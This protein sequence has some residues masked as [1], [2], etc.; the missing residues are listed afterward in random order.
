MSSR[1]AGN[2]AIT[3]RHPPDSRLERTG[4][5][6]IVC[7]PG[8]ARVVLDEALAHLWQAA[9]GQ[10][11]ARLAET[12]GA[13]DP[14]L[15]AKLLSLRAA[16]LLLPPLDVA[17]AGT[18]SP[19]P[20]PPPLVSAVIVS[21]NGCHHLEACLPSL[22]AQTYTRLEIILVDD[23]ST[24]GTETYVRENFPAVRLVRQ[25]NG[26]NFAAGC[27]HGIAHARGDL[28]F[29]LNNDT[30]LDPHC[31][32]ELVAAQ[33]GQDDVGGVAAMMRFY[34][35]RPFVNGL[36]AALRRFGFGYDLGIGSLDVG[37]F[38]IA[39]EV[40]LLCFG[41]ALI[42]RAAF[43]RTGPI[44][45]VYH[46]YYEDT[47][48]SYR[49]RAL[50]FRLVA[51]P[52]ALVYHKFGAST[53][54]LPSAF[55]KRLATRN[56]LWFVIK[57]F[58]AATI[59]LQ[60]LLYFTDDWGHLLAHLA[61][62]EWRL[63]AAIGRA[64]LGFWRGL[65]G[66]LAGRRR[67]WI[68][69]KRAAV[70]LSKLAAPFPPPQMHG[71]LPRL[72]AEL[73]EK[74]YQPFL[75]PLTHSQTRPLAHSP[76]RPRLLIISP[77][78]INASMGGV[79]IRY[80]ELARQLTS[81]ADVTLAVPNQSDLA[82]SEVAIRCYQE[83]HS[84]TLAPLVAAA[85]TVLLSG[86]TIYHHPFLRQASQH[87]VVDLYD[88]MVLE[89]LERFAGR[90]PAERHALHQLGVA[91]FN[92]LFSRGD[93]FICA[94]EKQRDYWLGALT[95]A[96]RVNPATYTADPTLRRLIDTVPFGLPDEPPL[97]ARPVL[98]GVWPGIGAGDK[99]I[100]WGGGLWDWLDPLAAIEAM[101][102]V[103]EQ[104]PE[105]RL[106][107][108]GTRHP[109]PAVPVSRMAQRAIER[110][111]VLGLKDQAV[112]FNEWTPYQERAGYLC[113]AD[114]GISLHG[115]HI[116]SRFAVRTRLM[117]YLWARLPMVVSGGD[118]LSDLVKEHGLGYVVAAGDVAT[119]ARCLVDVLQSP[120][121][122]AAFEPVVGTFGW[123]RVAEP[124]RRYVES[125]W[126]NE[127]DSRQ[128]DTAVLLKPAA[129][130]VRQLPQ[131][132]LASWRGQGI[133][134]LIRDVQSYIRWIRQL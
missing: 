9:N 109:N 102:A 34:D 79:G 95:A 36:G 101:P 103:L 125:P 82:D 24:D 67:T 98:K 64:W 37:Q 129:T 130:P 62:R 41:A 40:P 96:N 45:E 78:S 69:K 7:V 15:L 99:V 93:F 91:T 3:L 87:L 63:A 44:E 53:G 16:G 50:G 4:G 72:T 28:I 23:A 100:L 43:E 97:P 88:P 107:F 84:E 14:S 75:N 116:E 39:A 134:G 120:A 111:E 83:G 128:Q 48:W 12:M 132:A 51:A 74:Q 114:A 71:H 77:D 17:P 73:V 124:L 61:R 26:P 80:W 54:A 22:M 55:K 105:A 106:F 76:T 56:R 42:S 1:S 27:N 58:P 49:A 33:A 2:E 57:N 117:D 18:R 60:L 70:P 112:F 121:N 86:F 113:E 59:P 35:N 47:D 118:T 5:A 108:L 131:K 19:I 104:V 52:R 90:P 32:A 6:A 123:S 31:L 115:E 89:N 30:V 13:T 127:G 46:F 110:A 65:P 85:D 122:P 38:D 133:Q 11:P 21:R 20:N 10:T 92:E 126:R 68:N 8:S 119:V 29:L 81:I 66:I 94:S 25:V